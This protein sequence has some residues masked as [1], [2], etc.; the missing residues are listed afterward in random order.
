MKIHLFKS[1]L[2]FLGLCAAATGHAAATGQTVDTVLVEKQ[3]VFTQ[4]DVGTV[5][6]NEIG[7]V[8][9][10]RVEGKG[11]M[12]DNLARIAAPSYTT[13]AGSGVSSATFGPG[14]YDSMADSWHLTNSYTSQASL[15]AAF[16]SGIYTVTV[17]EIALALNLR[18]NFT[19]PGATPFGTASAGTWTDGVLYV[20]PTLALTITI[21]SVDFGSGNG[22]VG[23]NLH[24]NYSGSINYGAF[25]PGVLS[26]GSINIPASTFVTGQS[27]T[28]E[29][30]FNTLA[31]QNLGDNPNAPETN[32]TN[33]AVYTKLTT[34]TITAIPEPAAYAAFAGI[35]ALAGVLRVRGRQRAVRGV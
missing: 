1:A 19:Y 21:N 26:G 4:T 13:P 12:S 29:M 16:A 25:G 27:Y 35:A 7:W 15:D 6:Q 10:I 20:D 14:D 8:G 17:K 32:S 11:T 5:S 3:Q 22:H 2:V 34:F 30:Q 18:G 9:S 28:V 33:A 24:G 31:D 23:M